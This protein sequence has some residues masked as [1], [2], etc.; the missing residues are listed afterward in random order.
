MSTGWLPVASTIVEGAAWGRPPSINVD[1]RQRARS[2]GSAVG[3]RR[4]ALV[5]S[6]DTGCRRNAS[7]GSD[8]HGRHRPALGQHA[9]MLA[10]ARSTSVS[11]PGQNAAGRAFRQR[12]QH[13]PRTD[14]TDVGDRGESPGHGAPLRARTTV[15]APELAVG[16]QRGH[17]GCRWDTRPPAGHYAPHRPQPALQRPLAEPSLALP[18]TPLIDRNTSAPDDWRHVAKK[19]TRASTLK[20]PALPARLRTSRGLRPGV[21]ARAKAQ[22]TPGRELKVAP[23]S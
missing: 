15:T 5:E 7:E 6:P 11:G 18:A 4:F 16:L 10:A 2:S 19:K 23:R 12:R 20:L 1:C 13:R 3:G 21:L 9:S 14:L 17:K 22:E 8:R